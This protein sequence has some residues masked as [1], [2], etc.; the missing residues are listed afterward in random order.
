M[1]VKMTGSEFKAFYNDPAFWPE[2]VW[3]EDAELS[4]DG[5]DQPDGIDDEKLSDT[6]VVK[7]SEGVVFGPKWDGSDNPSLESYFKS[8]RKKQSS[9]FFT[10]ECD[11]AVF[12][13]VK[14]AIIA[15]G[16]KVNK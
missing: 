16:G 12:E 2:D 3:H 8:W 1:T 5:V 10:V 6:S 14:A 13:A 9:T 4:V 11:K 15:A 7:I